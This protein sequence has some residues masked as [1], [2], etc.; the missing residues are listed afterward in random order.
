M[1]SI[2]KRNPYQ[3]EARIRKRGYPT[4][5]KTFETKADAEAWAKEI[6]T[7]MNK[8]QFAS[9]KEAERCTL[10]ECLDRYIAEYIPRLKRPDHY[11]YLARAI[12]KRP[13]AQRI[14]ATIRAR[15][16]ADYRR[17]REAEGVKNSTILSDFMLLSRLFNFA[18]SDWGMEGL[19]NP[20]SVVSKPKP[21]KGRERRL[22][23]DEEERLLKESPP[24]FR[25]IILFALAT[26][27]RREEIATL[28]WK[29]VDLENRSALLSTTKNEETRSVPLSPAALN[30]LNNIPRQDS[31]ERIF[32]MGIHH[33]TNTM[34]MICRNAGI[35]NLRFHDL[36]HEATSRLFENTDL[37]IMEIRSITGHKTLQMLLRYTHLRTS[38]LADRLAG[39]KRI[40][41]PV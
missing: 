37:D 3:W 28:K 1:A 23:R 21:D 38:R 34:R 15:D 11:T 4:T 8:N 27:M 24:N 41:E 29:D 19:Q 17:E 10:A 13:I 5:C 14:M 9:A 20:I 25:P 26:A 33:I 36:R 7:A 2:R 12:Q 30:V 22:E 32:G 18:R 31:Q 40:T 35:E 16:I 6:E 39:A